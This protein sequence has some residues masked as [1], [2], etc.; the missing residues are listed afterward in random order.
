MALLTNGGGKRPTSLA[1]CRGLSAFDTPSLALGRL[2]PTGE[3]GL[4][5]RC[6]HAPTAVGGELRATGGGKRPTSLARCR[7]L[8]AFD[9]PSLALGRL[10]PTGEMGLAVRC[11]H[12][13]TA[14]GGELRANG[15][16]GSLFVART[17]RPRSVE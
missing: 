6:P 13:P 2:R 9:T 8:S 5:V 14:V 3:M 15:E 7:G 12:A 11:P 17:L 4:A 16:T 10:R 1:R